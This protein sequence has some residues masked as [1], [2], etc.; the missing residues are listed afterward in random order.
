MSLYD[1]SV[2]QFKQMLTNLDGWLGTAV[3]HAKKK[4]FDPNVLATAR[5]APDQYPL[6]RQVQSACDSA[7]FAAARL[8]G[9]EAPKHPDTETTID[10][11]R[12]RVK[13]C[14]AFLDTV[15]ADDFKGAD[16]REVTLSFMPGKGIFGKDYLNQMALPNFYFHATHTYAILRHNGVDLGKMQYIGNMNLHDVKQ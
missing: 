5:L 16:T 10:E 2:P 13:A 14:I 12:A 8:T 7:K 11:L 15:S 3:E 1:A 6:I 4:N 9:K